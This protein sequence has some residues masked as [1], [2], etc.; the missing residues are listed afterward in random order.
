MRKFEVRLLLSGAAPVEVEAE[1]FTHKG[2]FIQFVEKINCEQFKGATQLLTLAEFNESAV[3][4]I[5][6]HGEVEEK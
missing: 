3:M 1:E 4:A 6:D 5:I 2:G